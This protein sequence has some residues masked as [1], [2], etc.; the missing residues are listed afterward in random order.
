MGEK[1]P[2]GALDHRLFWDAMDHLDTEALRRIETEPGRRMVTEF[3][4]DLCGL[5]L[6][7][8]NFAT[9][10]DSAND[11]APIAQTLEPHLDR[12]IYVTLSTSGHRRKR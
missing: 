12:G 6:D 5:V 2:A 3:G 1:T 7:M 4:L 8:T 11:R 10:I 9:Y